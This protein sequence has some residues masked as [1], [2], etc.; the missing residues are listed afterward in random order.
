VRR[1]QGVQTND[2]LGWF[3]RRWTW[4]TVFSKMEM[5]GAQPA[6]VL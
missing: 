1:P 2:L 5:L 4:N 6:L 3:Y